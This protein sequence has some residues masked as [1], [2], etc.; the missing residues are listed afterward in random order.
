MRRRGEG[1]QSS[2]TVD[3]ELPQLYGADS[4]LG[5]AAEADPLG[6]GARLQASVAPRVEE[7]L[8]AETVVADD[9]PAVSL[10]IATQ[11]EPMVFRAVPRTGIASPLV[12]TAPDVMLA[13][14]EPASGD[15]IE[16]IYASAPPSE[17]I[18]PAAFLKEEAKPRAGYMR[19]VWAIASVLALVLLLAQ[20]VWMFRA[21]LATRVPIL[22][23]LLEQ[24]CQEFAC[25]VGY[26]REPALLAIE[27]SSIE[28]WTP[29]LPATL[30][31]PAQFADAEAQGALPEAAGATV[32]A[33]RLA[34]RAVLR[35]R[36]PFAQAWPAIELS[37]TDLSENVVARRVLLPSVYLAPGELSQPLHAGEE[38]VLRI[39]VDTLDAHASGYRIALFFP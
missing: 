23:P 3:H 32:P 5:A 12:D 36:A 30:S 20:A 15:V 17:A 35:N 10:P 38:R 13:D 27:S 6:A 8:P 14:T 21:E 25:T 37:L 34:L 33:R 4:S 19:V 31:G 1:L 29:H 2:Q 16:P 39:P 28:P 18:P 26:P 7:E 9:P 22:R 11:A 24:I